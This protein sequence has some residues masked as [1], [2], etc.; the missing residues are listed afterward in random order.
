MIE[1]IGKIPDP[2]QWIV[3]SSDHVVMSAARSRRMQTMR[4]SDFAVLLEAP[5]APDIDA[6]EEAQVNLSAEEVNEWLQF[7]GDENPPLEI[8][9]P[10]GEPATKPKPSKTASAALSNP[11]A[12]K[13]GNANLSSQEVD[14]WMRFFGKGDNKGEKTRSKLP[15]AKSGKPQPPPKPKVVKSQ[16]QPVLPAPP[17]KS[18][19][20]E[21][22]SPPEK[23]A[24]PVI[25]KSEARP[26]HFVGGEQ[27]EIAGK[28]FLRIGLYVEERRLGRVTA[29]GT[30]YVIGDTILDPDVGFVTQ[31]RAPKGLPKGHV[32]FAPNLAVEVITSGDSARQV[33]DRVERYLEAGTRLVWLVYADEQV[34]D[35]W[36]R[37]DKGALNKRKV[38]ID[39]TLDGEDVLPG[40]KL[41]VRAIFPQ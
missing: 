37:A 4:S 28:I 11:G 25:I 30:A 29:A 7:F 17:V 26:T 15:V 39:G 1:R 33:L 9:P 31:S 18:V 14:D 13:T 35:V 24:P 27:G 12:A 8:I 2:V 22:P 10:P 6:G 19:Q 34:V 38:G 41:P 21:V 20:K 5:P 36:R 3:V 40:F 32:P 23:S 16:P